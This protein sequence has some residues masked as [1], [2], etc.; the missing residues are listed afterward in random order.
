MREIK[1]R[2]WDKERNE[3]L[4]V[5]H[6]HKGDEVD[7]ISKLVGFTHSETLF[8]G[9]DIE[10]MQYTG[11]KDKNGKEIYE[12]DVL[13]LE[14]SKCQIQKARIL[15]TVIFSFS[16]FSIEIKRVDIWEKYLIPPPEIDSVLW[17][18]NL[19]GKELEVIGNIY[20]NPELL[21]AQKEGM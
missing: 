20:E 2:G 18:L 16:S 11:L 19:S 13:Q 10:L 6:W 4:R 15:G 17:F 8:V 7:S 1:F 21:Q 14:N 12:G 3:M 5:F 9:K